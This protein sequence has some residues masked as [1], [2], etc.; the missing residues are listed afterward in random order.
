MA[1]TALLTAGLLAMVLSTPAATPLKNP[2]RL[3]NQNPVDLS[4]LFHWWTNRSGERPLRAW[5]HITGAIVGTNSWGW[6]VNARV[7][8]DG[9]GK[10]GATGQT[11]KAGERK[12]ILE[13][14]PR[15]EQGE[16]L[17]LKTRLAAM[18]AQHQALDSQVA[19]AQRQVKAIADQQ[20]G[21]RQHHS[22]HLAQEAASWKQAETQAKEQLKPLDRQIREVN[23]KLAAFHDRQHYSVD[24]LALDKSQEV[25]GVHLYDHGVVLK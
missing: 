16:F 4:P 14:P 1:R 11:Y 25:G 20:K 18:E 12:I 13:N 19:E 24:C 2:K 5:V 8:G 21:S 3:I 10:T 7:E 15:G 17:S 22:R 9:T 23:G 6:V